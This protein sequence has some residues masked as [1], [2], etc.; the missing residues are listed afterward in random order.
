MPDNF[1]SMQGYGFYIW[2]A[3]GITLVVLGG[4]CIASLRRLKAARLR[5]VRLEQE[6]GSPTP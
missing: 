4:L 6:H 5:L 1:F 2:S 3:Y